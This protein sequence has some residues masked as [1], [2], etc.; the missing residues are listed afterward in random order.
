M[1]VQRGA[2]EA[3]EAP[4]APH[5]GGRGRSFSHT[6]AASHLVVRVDSVPSRSRINQSWGLV[7]LHDSVP[8]GSRI[9]L[10]NLRE[11]KGE[12]VEYI[13]RERKGERV[14]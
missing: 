8:S 1:G 2:Q 4:Y 10:A 12:R 9:N 13:E 3:Q 14:L 11:R 7:Q 6:P 5:S